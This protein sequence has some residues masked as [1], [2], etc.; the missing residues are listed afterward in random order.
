MFPLLWF[1]LSFS[2][3]VTLAESSEWII[4]RRGHVTTNQT[5]IKLKES[6]GSNSK[7]VKIPGP[8][9]PRNPTPLC[10]FS[11]MYREVP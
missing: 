5:I 9:R 10:V 1:G 11:I 8:D 3:V 2:N 7:K 4:D 6:K